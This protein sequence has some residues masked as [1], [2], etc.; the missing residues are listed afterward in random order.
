M[1]CIGY[2]SRN[3]EDPSMEHFV[4]EKQV[5]RYVKGTVNFGLKY[6]R[7]IK[8]LLVSYIDSECGG[9]L[10]DNKSTSGVFFFSRGNIVS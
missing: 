5:F 8:L 7:G 2:L 6:R 1:F 3:I 10:N 9:D 4:T